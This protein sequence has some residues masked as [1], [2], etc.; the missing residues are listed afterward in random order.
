MIKTTFLAVVGLA[1]SLTASIA[2]AGGGPSLGTFNISLGEVT[3][4]SN[5]K[6]VVYAPV[7]LHTSHTLR[8][9]LQTMGDGSVRT[10]RAYRG[11]RLIIFGTQIVSGE[12][13]VLS[14]T[15]FFPTD[16]IQMVDIPVTG[17]AQSTG[18]VSVICALIGLLQP[19]DGTSTPALTTIPAKT[20]LT[21]EAF[22]PN[23]TGTGL[24]LPA[25]QKIRSAAAR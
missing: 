4:A 5:A 13:P 25:V 1:L 21:L 2:Q 23:G 9:T 19:A 24:L 22:D 8:V 10:D 11:Y 15:D 18:H 3:R 16:Q 17:L 6:A 20:L 12:N 7:T 14:T